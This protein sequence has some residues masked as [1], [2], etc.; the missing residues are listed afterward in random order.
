[1]NAKKEI[2]LLTE[3]QVKKKLGIKD[4]RSMKKK[5]IV[6]FVS[7][8]PDM[9]PEV[10]MKVI[11]QFPEVRKM[12][13]ESLRDYRGAVEKS[14]EL[15]SAES[16]EVFNSF[17]MVIEVLSRQLDRDDISPEERTLL[18][19]KLA[20]LPI[21]KGAVRKDGQKFKLDNLKIYAGVFI[22][23]I[24]GAAVMLGAKGNIPIPSFGGSDDEDEEE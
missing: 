13:V 12:M 22:G 24:V 7:A 18:I 6:N 4:F 21:Q 16:A 14:M 3:E 17:D 20:E 5:D 19:N 9:E 11:E 2:R 10:A 15:D 8:I 23:A 1:M